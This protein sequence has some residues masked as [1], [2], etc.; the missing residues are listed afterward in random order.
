MTGRSDAAFFI[1]D[2]RLVSSTAR[3]TIV[4]HPSRHRRRSPVR[5]SSLR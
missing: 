4:K 3:P 1:L 5:D 2:A